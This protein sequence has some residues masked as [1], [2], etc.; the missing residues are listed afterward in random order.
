MER[1]TGMPFEPLIRTKNYAEPALKLRLLFVIC[2]CA[3][4]HCD[5]IIEP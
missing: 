3:A 4:I 5:K 1:Y 2:L